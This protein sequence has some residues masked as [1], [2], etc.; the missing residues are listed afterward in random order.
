MQNK[1]SLGLECESLKTQGPKIKNK[2]NC[3][4]QIV[5]L[6]APCKTIKSCFFVLIDK[7]KLYFVK[8]GIN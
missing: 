2:K 5:V 3:R 7:T 4:D 8:M 1:L 6:Y